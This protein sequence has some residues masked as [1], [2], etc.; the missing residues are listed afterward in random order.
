LEDLYRDRERIENDLSHRNSSPVT[1]AELLKLQIYLDFLTGRI[2]Q[3]TDDVKQASYESDESRGRL[4]DRMI[5]EKVW[6]NAR[7]KAFQSYRS[8]RLAREQGELDE[9]AVVRA[10]MVRA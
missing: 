4:K 9:M 5:D 1:L 2:E 6:L 10:A 3:Q 7:E 8:E